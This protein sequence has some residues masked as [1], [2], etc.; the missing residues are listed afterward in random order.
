M[1]MKTDRKATLSINSAPRSGLSA[2]TQ[3][4]PCNLYTYLYS[5]RNISIFH[6]IVHSSWEMEKDSKKSENNIT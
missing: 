2:D 5:N 3:N 1:M 4:K 6:A